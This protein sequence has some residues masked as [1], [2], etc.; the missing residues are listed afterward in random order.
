MAS[1]RSMF[2]VIVAAAA[3]Q[4]QPLVERPTLTEP[5]APVA[6]VQTGGAYDTPAPEHADLVARA[7]RRAQKAE[8]VA[9][10]NSRSA[11]ALGRAASE[12]MALAR[13]TGDYEAYASADRL[14]MAAFATNDALAPHLLRARLHYSLHR[15][16]QAEADLSAHL[17]LPRVTEKQA[18][19][20]TLLAA[21][22]AFQRGRYE[23]AGRGYEAAIEAAETNA[24]LASLA[25]YRWRTGEFEAAEE[26][27][28]RVLAR[29][30]S[31]QD[32]AEVAA[33]THLQLGLMDLERGRHEHAL[34]HYRDGQRCIRGFWLIEEH[35]AEVLALLGRTSEAK[36]MYR[37]IIARTGNPEF[38]DALAGIL[39]EE[40]ADDE[41][42]VLVAGARAAYEERLRRF[43]EATVGHALEHYLEFGE[44]DRALELAEG[45]HAL[46][47]NA[48][49]KVALTRAYLGAGRL[50]DATRTI[51]AAL[52]SPIRM[53]DLHETAAAVY[54]AL[55]RAQ[56]AEA[57]RAQAQ[58]LAQR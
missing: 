54:A 39:R 10:K 28:E 4:R 18:S 48:E 30:G 50:E 2:L 36:T 1:R 15:L 14:L 6:L 58:R 23:E 47:P 56:D 7:T 24:T 34:A 29:T 12:S 35:I 38:M 8:A 37:D 5:P 11:I 31:R 46:R 45:N 32:D 20:E 27:Y 44:A 40:G 42:S 19:A 49:A 55:G 9:T 16:D 22:L 13:L 3:C 21:D 57:Q 41:A 33:W 26:L 43:P 53:V 25:Y 17:A 52:D 51:E